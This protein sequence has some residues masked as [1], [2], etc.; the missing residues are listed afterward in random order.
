M[1]NVV[2]NSHIDVQTLEISSY[3]FYEYKRAEK[4][5]GPA[6]ARIARDDPSTLPGDDPS[7]TMR[8]KF[9]LEFET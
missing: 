5:V 8:G 3:T 1:E 6:V 4:Q 9:G 7:N 2:L